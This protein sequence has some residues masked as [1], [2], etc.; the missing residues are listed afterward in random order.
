MAFFKMLFFIRIFEKY[1]SFV[2]M[3]YLCLGKLVP[4]MICYI[5]FMLGFCLCFKIL[6]MEIDDEVEGAV[7]LSYN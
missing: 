5:L 1:G 7:G 2:Q 3:I 4:F 6:G